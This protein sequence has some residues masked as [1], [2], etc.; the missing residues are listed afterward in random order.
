MA[1][2]RR[3]GFPIKYAAMRPKCALAW[4]AHDPSACVASGIGRIGP[5]S[6]PNG[7][8]LSKRALAQQNGAEGAR[9]MKL[10]SISNV[11]LAIPARALAS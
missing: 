8:T 5:I 10:T 9:S 7:S 6:N 11:E 1:W 3:R 4:G 2:P